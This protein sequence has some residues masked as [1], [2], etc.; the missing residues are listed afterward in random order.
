MSSRAAW[1]LVAGHIHQRQHSLKGQPVR[2]PMHLGKL[3]RH[4][5]HLQT[6]RA[7]E[8]LSPARQPGTPS[9]KPINMSHLHLLHSSTLVSSP[10]TPA[11]NFCHFNRSSGAP[12]IALYAMGGNVEPSPAS[13]SVWIYRRRLAVTTTRAV[14]L[15]LFLRHAVFHQR[16]WIVPQV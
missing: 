2:M 6:C 12:S 3:H 14:R 10:S 9:M 16:G 13:R 7:P 1:S 5:P 11:P 15:H 4:R 8:T